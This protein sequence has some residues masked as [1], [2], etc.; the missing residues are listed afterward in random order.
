MFKGCE[1]WRF[2]VRFFKI[3]KINAVFSSSSSAEP[4]SVWFFSSRLWLWALLLGNSALKNGTDTEKFKNTCKSKGISTFFHS[5]SP[6]LL[7]SMLFFRAVARQSHTQANI[8][9]KRRLAAL[10]P[11]CFVCLFFFGAFVFR[12][13]GPQNCSTTRHRTSHSRRQSAV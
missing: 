7:Y 5:F 8:A 9:W 13:R 10:A 4:H 2:F 12:R 3:S 6:K 1:I 11:S